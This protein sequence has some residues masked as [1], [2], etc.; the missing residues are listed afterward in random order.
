[1]KMLLWSGLWLLATSVYAENMPVQKND[2]AYGLPIETTGEAAIYQLALPE[3]VYTHLTK[4]DFRDLRVFNAAGE[5]VPHS[6]RRPD[7]PEVAVGDPLVVPFFPY[8]V[9][10]PGEQG[11][12]RVQIT[13]NDQGTLISSD[14]GDNADGAERVSAYLI[15]VSALE[16][17]PSKLVF[18]WESPQENFVAPVRVEG[19]DDLSQWHTLVPQASLVRLFFAGHEL[20]RR[21]IDLPGGAY[22]YL[23]LN[24]PTTTDGVSLT[25]VKAFFSQT[26]EPTEPVWVELTGAAVKDEQDTFEYRTIG[27]LPIEWAKVELPE[28]NSLVDVKLYSR[29][30]EVASWRMRHTG[31][32]YRL[33]VDGES[34]MS[35]PAKFSR[36]S[37]LLWRLEAVS[38]L[39]GLGASVP[40]LK[41]GYTP[42]QLYFLARGEKPFILAFGSH[43]APNE[44]SQINV[45]LARIDDKKSDA[46]I[47]EAHAGEMITL[48]GNE[49][50]L[51]PSAPF[52]WQRVILWG[53]LVVGVVVLGTMAW[54]LAKQ[55]S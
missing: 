29:D 52:P 47:S 30:G 16:G 8:E 51:A 21:E 23:K 40:V 48:G 34:L 42:H 24:W 20:G 43:E 19:S 10:K 15:D 28:N 17:A 13:I 45:L 46:F 7:K 4:A 49:K 50:L 18:N 54:R 41:L 39:S 11:P 3:I 12:A 22:K 25:E 1:M 36:V 32:F 14:V 5:L 31:S 44:E 6:L 27:R 38:D 37:D 53:V 26:S 2:F 9:V 35:V 33:Q 55:M